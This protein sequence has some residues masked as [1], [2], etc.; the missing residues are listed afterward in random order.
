MWGD[1]DGDGTMDFLM[2]G[3]SST[4]AAT[5]LYKNDGQGNF[6][7][8]INDV[9]GYQPFDNFTL[10]S[11]GGSRSENRQPWLTRFRDFGT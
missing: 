10:A 5:T 9:A 7:P 8:F 2:V 6:T 3:S 11:G 1:F 4:L